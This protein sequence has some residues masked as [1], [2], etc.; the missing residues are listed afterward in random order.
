MS[1]ANAAIAGIAAAIAALA[2]VG[3]IFL[4]KDKNE[5]EQPLIHVPVILRSCI[6]H[7]KRICNFSISTAS[8][9]F[10][11]NKIYFP[12]SLGLA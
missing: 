12:G 3:G 9:G 7:A 2:I 10:D 8:R 11:E 1:G 6:R 4:T 5:G